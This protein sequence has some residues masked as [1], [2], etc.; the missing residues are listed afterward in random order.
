MYSEPHHYST[1]DIITSV[2][3]RTILARLHEISL[4]SRHSFYNGESICLGSKPKVLLIEQY[5]AS[6]FTFLGL[7]FL[8]CKLELIIPTF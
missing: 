1:A 2:L 7:N 8:I 4:V 5:G 3:S 6:H